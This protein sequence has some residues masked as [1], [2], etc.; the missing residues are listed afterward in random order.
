[1]TRLRPSRASIWLLLAAAL[2]M[3]ALVPHGY[4]PERAA[5]GAIAVRLCNSDGVW[6]IPLEHGA[7]PGKDQ[8]RAEQRCAF[9]GLGSPATPPLA[10]PQMAPRPAVRAAFALDRA[11]VEI[12]AT[13][14]LLPPATGPPLTV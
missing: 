5:G 8:Q 12:G 4:M 3:R 7:K 14:R 13:P 2:F 9:A 11:A 6:L 1:M 10:L